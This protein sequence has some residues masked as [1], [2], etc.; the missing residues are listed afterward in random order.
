MSLFSITQSPNHPI[1]SSRGGQTTLELAIL[2]AIVAAGALGMQ[3]YAK[4]A[5]S[6][7]LRQ[8]ADSIGQGQFYLPGRTTATETTT[9]TS[10][11][12]ETLVEETGDGTP[13]VVGLGETASR[14]FIS[15]ADIFTRTEHSV[16]ETVELDPKGALFE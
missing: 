3:V 4:R 1:T 13:D 8:A 14:T 12:Q 2:V 6:G 15:T 9:V 7:R 11:I 10:E 5:L 16:D